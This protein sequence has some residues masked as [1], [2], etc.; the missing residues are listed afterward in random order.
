MKPMKA[1]VHLA[2][3]VTMTVMYTGAALAD[4]FST[5]VTSDNRSASV[6][7]NELVLARPPGSGGQARPVPAPRPGQPPR[8]GRPTPGRPPFVPKPGRTGPVDHSR[9]VR[10]Q[11]PQH[12]IRHQQPSHL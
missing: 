2:L 4:N 3:G 12:V 5:G 6:N 11:D 1:V 9:P 7:Q 10:Q 8:P